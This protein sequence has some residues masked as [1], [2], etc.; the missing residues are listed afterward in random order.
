MRPRVSAIE[1][2]L[3][4]NLLPFGVRPMAERDLSQLAEIEREA[5]PTLFPPTSF[6]REM[7]NRL[8]NYL[9]AWRRD[10]AVQGDRSIGNG[11][12]LHGGVS[13]QGSSKSCDAA[14]KRHLDY[15]TQNSRIR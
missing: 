4:S 5:F 9:V 6:R 13:S 1:K 2:K 8:A 3:Q 15:I 10:D 7:R 12:D 14:D 11:A